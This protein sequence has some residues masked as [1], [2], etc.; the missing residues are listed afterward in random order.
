MSDPFPSNPFAEGNFAPW[1]EEEDIP[2]LRV[3]GE[4]PESLRGSYYRNGSNPPYPPGPNYHWFFGDGMIHAFHFEGGRCS[5]LNRWVRTARFAAQ[6][7]YGAAI[8][9]GI[10]P[11]GSPD[12]RAEGVSPNASNT[13][14]IWHAGRL[15]SLW[16]AGPPHELDPITLETRGIHDY[17]GDFYRVR[18]DQRNPDVMTA[19]PK[20]D[21]DTGEW[22]GFG[23]SPVAPWLVYHTV[24]REGRLTRSFEL[25]AP[26]PSMMHDFLVSAEHALFPIFPAVFDFEATSGAGLPLVW[27]PERGTRLG[28]LPRDG[29]VDDML[30]F[31]HEGCYSFHT[32]N[33]QTRGETV[34]A[35]LFIFPHGPLA[36]GPETRPPTLRRWTVDLAGGG[37]TEQQLDDAPAEFGCVDPRHVGKSYRHAFTLGSVDYRNMKGQPEGF[38]SL[39]HYDLELDRREVHRLGAGDVAG[40]PC[41]IPRAPDAAEGDGY[42]LSLVYRRSEHRSDLLV[43]DTQDFEGAPAAV[44]K[45]PHRIPFG[46]HGSWRPAGE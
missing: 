34:I 25:E 22:I 26:F 18:A 39:F 23:Y 13:H 16:E 7:K 11:K 36:E 2:D 9:G 28:V 6:R 46:F 1:L 3:E 38:N 24:D 20:I 35:D 42:V 33:A 21:P 5:Y 14:V 37:L 41:F 15:L 30:W 4:I 40:E 31:E 12:P 29:R 45:M 43:I 19:H 44:I 10:G 27:Q 17:D 8:F 32:V